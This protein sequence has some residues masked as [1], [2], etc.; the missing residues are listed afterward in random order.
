MARRTI[1][2]TLRPEGGAVAGS[3]GWLEGGAVEGGA[4]NAEANGDLGNG[5]VGGFEQ[6]AD[7]LDFLSRQLGG[8]ATVVAAGSG[9]FEAG[10]G[11]FAD[12]VALKLRQ[13]GE[14]IKDELSCGC[15]GF[16][17]LGVTTPNVKIV[18]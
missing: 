3:A 12:Q 17:L 14:D 10:D 5:D 9:G 13:S 16:D 2:R 1:L 8:P 11:S 18:R 4:R 6:G 7:G 15:T